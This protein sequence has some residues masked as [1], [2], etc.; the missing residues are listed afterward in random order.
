MSQEDLF[1]AIRKE[2]V[3]VFAGAGFSR[4][5]GYPVG[6]RLAEMLVERLTPEQ[7]LKISV[8][9]PLDY[10]SEEIIRV[11]FG[12]RDMVNE[13]LDEAFGA[14]PV[15][16]ADHDLFASIPH[17]KTVITTNYDALF[18]NVYNDSVLIFREQ[19][20][21]RWDDKKVNILKIHGDLS[22]KSSIILTR[23]DYAKFYRKDYSTPFWS[24]IIKAIATKSILFLGY[25]YED[26]NVWAIFEH[27]Y[28][29]LGGN[30]KAAFFI[31]PGATDEKIAFLESKNIHY[32]KHTGESFLKAVLSN[33]REH[34]FEDMRNKWLSPETFRKFTN[35]HNLAI[36]LQDT[37]DGYQIQSIAGRNGD[38]MNGGMNFTID[39]GSDFEKSF[40]QFF[41]HGNI[42]ELIFGETVSNSL[43]MDVEGLKLFGAGELSQISVKKTPK[44]IPFDLIF[45]SE[46]FEITNLSAQIYAGKKSLIVRTKIHTLSFQL[47]LNYANPNDLDSKWSMEHDAIYRNVNEELV[48]HEFLKYF[49]SQKTAT[50][51]LNKDSK[52]VKEC[53]TYDE[54]RIKDAEIHI[55]YFKGL[56]EVEKAFDVRFIDFYPIDQQSVDDLNWVLHV[57]SGGRFDKGES[58][59]LKFGEL[60][61]ETI[62][63]LS[64]LKDSASPMELTMNSDLIMVLH[65]QRLPIP[66]VHTEIPFPEITNLEELRNGGKVLKVRSGTGTIY[67]KFLLKPFPSITD[68]QV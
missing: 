30:R 28:E 64:K 41:E 58:M 52:I 4:Y 26:P 62:D 23:A 17:F 43:R 5:A 33:L 12:S 21:S 38:P 65:D 68:G 13:V 25:G 10:L 66:G 34:I 54:S 29:H 47:D 51:Y 9:A 27:V 7:K 56:K 6:G 40:R 45:S 57:I 22:D 2:D 59:E 67:Q 15:S 18:E 24:L 50:I 19:D 20:V 53:P 61:P 49:F 60:S 44:I 37:G 31:S 1:E 63:N 8:G 3:V 42:E 11:N 55:N 16:T 48:V 35:H 39:S 32:I 36:A 46:G 14:Q